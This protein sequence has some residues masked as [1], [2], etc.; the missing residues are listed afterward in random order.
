MFSGT[1]IANTRHSVKFRQNR[2]N[3]CRYIAILPFSKMV[4]A[5]ILD[6]KK[7]KFLPAAT[8]GRPN[9]RKPA[10]L[11]QDRGQYVSEIWR[12]FDFSRWRLSAMLDF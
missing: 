5:A 7:F 6:F 1:R 11:H 2:S 10:K 12:I 8:L 4:V 3:G 9:L